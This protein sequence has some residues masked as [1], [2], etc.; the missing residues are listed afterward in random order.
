MMTMPI[1]KLRGDAPSVQQLLSVT[2][3]N[4]NIGNTFTLTCNGKSITYTAIAATITDV[5][6]GL[7]A[8]L[9]NPTIG[10]FGEVTAT[11]LGG[12]SG[13]LLLT[14]DENLEVTITASAS[15]GTATLTIATLQ[16]ATGPNFWKSPQNWTLARIPCGACAAPPVQGNPSLVAGGSL[17][18][19]TAQFYVI[20]ATNANGETT[21]SNEKTITPSG[22][23]LSV[24]LNWAQV[25]GAT[26]YKIYRSTT[27]GSYT[28]KFLIAIASG[29]TL[30]YTDVSNGTPPGVST[31]IGDDVYLDSSAAALT[32]GLDQSTV[33]LLSSLNITPGFSGSIGLPFQNSNGYFEY[34]ETYLKIKAALVSINGTNM[35]S[36]TGSDTQTVTF[37]LDLLTGASAV[38]V[39]SL[40]NATPGLSLRGSAITSLNIQQGI[41]NVATNAGESSSIT[42]I[43]VGS[44]GNPATDVTLTLGSGVTLSTITADGGALTIQS[45]VTTLTQQ[46]GTILLLGSVSITT[47]TSEKGTIDNRAAGTIASGT[48]GA[49]AIYQD[50]EVPLTKTITNLTMEAGSQFLNPFGNTVVTNGIKLDNCE[51]SEVTIILPPNKTISWA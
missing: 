37:N 30:T 8:L 39:L 31:A 45:N 51:L 11:D 38:T 40:G 16:N 19:G 50:E 35:T 21:V 7:A 46:D 18:S 47:L 41:A 24:S 25:D 2:P 10:E 48:L 26:G 4:V 23:N 14:T 28:N 9:A 36:Q 44:Q 29:T 13:Y 3:A 5:T 27:T 34:R 1:N 32:I 15:G 43:L 12:T 33:G 49:D 22:G 17:P 20:T 42:T 6:A